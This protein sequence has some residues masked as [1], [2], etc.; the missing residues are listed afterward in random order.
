MEGIDIS[1]DRQI[2]DG[3][4]IFCNAANLYVSSNLPVNWRVIICQEK[5]NMGSFNCWCDGVKFRFYS[6]TI[7]VAVKLSFLITTSYFALCLWSVQLNLVL[8]PWSSVGCY[9]QLFMLPHPILHS[10]FPLHTWFY[11]SRSKKYWSLFKALFC[12]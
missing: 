12:V 11:S 5:K 2:S 10:C 6:L 8:Q 9:P 1:S 7:K 3:S 4:S